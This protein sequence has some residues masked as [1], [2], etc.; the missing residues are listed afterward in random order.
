MDRLELTDAERAL[1]RR[2]AAVGG[3]HT[4]RPD[5]ENLLAF[6]AFEEGI[7]ASLLSLQRKHLVHIDPAATDLVAVPGQP[8]R[9]SRITAELTDLG[10]EA[11]QPGRQS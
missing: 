10:R 1:L 9:F 7:V 4:F 5:G 2:L 8:D 6:R 11:L 3:R